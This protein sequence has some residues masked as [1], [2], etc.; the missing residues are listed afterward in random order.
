MPS[1]DRKRF[2]IETFVSKIKIKNV[3][4]GGG[5]KKEKVFLYLFLVIP[6]DRGQRHLI[7]KNRMVLF[8]G[9]VVLEER[10]FYFFIFHGYFS[11]I[12]RYCVSTSVTTT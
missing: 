10:T 9:N 5:E 11:T 7:Y 6:R 3:Q 12:F 8:D 4:N 2:L 1:M